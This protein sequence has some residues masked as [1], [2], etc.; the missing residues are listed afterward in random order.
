MSNKK[1]VFILGAGSSA[2]FGMS[3]GEKL[4]GEIIDLLA[5]GAHGA[6]SEQTVRFRNILINRGGDWD[7]LM[8][9]WLTGR[10][11]SPEFHF[12]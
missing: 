7:H 6:D 3:T 5:P 12:D 10:R 9:A 4:K 2:E 1:M 8:D 11:S